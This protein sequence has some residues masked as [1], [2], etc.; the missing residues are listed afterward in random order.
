MRKAGD[1]KLFAKVLKALL[2]NSEINCPVLNKG[3]DFEDQHL[4]VFDVLHKDIDEIFPIC[5]F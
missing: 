4:V 1:K 2:G 3:D 5:F